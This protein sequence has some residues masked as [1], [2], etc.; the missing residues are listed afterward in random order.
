MVINVSEAINTDTAEIITVERDGGTGD[1]VDGLFVKGGIT[2]F[3]TLASVQ[4]PTPKQLQILPEGER[5]KNPRLFISRKPLR[6]TSDRD[7]TIADIVIYKGI[8]FK[9]IMPADWESYGH[10]MAFGVRIQ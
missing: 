6:T 4:Q 1:F 7:G 9:I 5:D 3:K 10:T 8:R 2:T